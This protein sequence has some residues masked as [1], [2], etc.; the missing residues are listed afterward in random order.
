MK[1]ILVLGDGQLGLMLA[2]AASRFGIELDRLSP[3]Q[4]VLYRGTGRRGETL[5]PRWDA[6]EYDLIT[7]EREHL[8]DCE[9]LCS[10]ASH[11]GAGT[12]QAVHLLADRRSQKQLLDSLDVPTATWCVASDS[13]ALQSFGRSVGT[14]LV[15]KSARGG[16][17]G[18]NQWRI[19]SVDDIARLSMALSDSIAER[20]VDFDR[21]LSLIG[22]RRADG[23]CVFYPLVENHHAQGMLR[24]TIAPAVCDARL[25]RRAQSHLERIMTALDYRGVMAMEL[26]EERGQLLVNELA[27]RVHNSGHWT[28]AGGC[29][30]S[31]FELHL[32]ALCD[33]PLP[34]PVAVGSTAMINLIGSAF[35]PAWLS[36]HDA[37]FHW[38]AK[39]PRPA[40]KLGHINFHAPSASRLCASLH[41]ARDG[42][43]AAH[44][45]YIDLLIQRL[46]AERVAG[47]E[48]A[49]FHNSA[50]H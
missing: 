10:M 12:L 36:L 48:A 3:E 33:W 13:A 26:F 19:D 42:M 23:K 6:G 5:P 35:D 1:R 24:F 43:D 31:Q 30:I 8:P 37:A 41:Q 11:P 27:P 14:A 32:R 39:T 25:Q 20:A 49:A 15:V 40:R 46:S 47:A 22:A 38:Y 17:D 2:E 7:A 34:S 50:I 45:L 18:R 9:L 4:R 29:N 28:L 16:Y 21:E 44:R